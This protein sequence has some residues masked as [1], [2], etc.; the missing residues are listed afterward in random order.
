MPR[1]PWRSSGDE[2][3]ALPYRHI[4]KP[5]RRTLALAC[6]IAYEMMRAAVYCRM[7]KATARRCRSTWHVAMRRFAGVSAEAFYFRS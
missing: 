3:V 1:C 6:C 2:T 7:S 4:N 5:A